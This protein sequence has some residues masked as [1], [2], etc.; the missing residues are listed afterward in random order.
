MLLVA[1]DATAFATGFML[2]AAP[3]AAV[4]VVIAVA[5]AKNFAKELE[6]Q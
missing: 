4:A 2:F 3:M 1:I 5:V 6:F